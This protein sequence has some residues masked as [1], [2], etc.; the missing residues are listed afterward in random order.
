MRV[1]DDTICASG[2]AVFLINKASVCF[3]PHTF[4]RL[5]FT[6]KSRDLC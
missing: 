2:E 3:P 5:F 1:K 4:L 6:M